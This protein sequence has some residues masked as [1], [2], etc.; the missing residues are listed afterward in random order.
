MLTGFAD[1]PSDKGRNSENIDLIVSKPARL[2]DL[3]QA[4][5]QILP[6]LKHR[7]NSDRK[8]V[9]EAVRRTFGMRIHWEAA[10]SYRQVQ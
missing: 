5:L 6:K 7:R 2:D 9:K 1:L 3:R 4:I 8:Q 10:P